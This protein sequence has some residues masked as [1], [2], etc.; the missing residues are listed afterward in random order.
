MLEQ[1]ITFQHG[2]TYTWSSGVSMMR[3]AAKERVNS[4]VVVGGRSL[5]GISN[6]HLNILPLGPRATASR[7]GG[8][9]GCHPRATI[10]EGEKPVHME[11]MLPYC[12]VLSWDVLTLN[13]NK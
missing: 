12:R 3:I 5:G 4:S 8:R 7:V 9:Y 11:M 13:S 2:S 6:K 10:E 1:S